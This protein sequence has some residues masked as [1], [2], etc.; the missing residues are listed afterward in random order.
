MANLIFNAGLMK[1]IVLIGVVLLAGCGQQPQEVQ[2]KPNTWNAMKVQ[3]NNLVNQEELS[4]FDKEILKISLN[5]TNKQFCDNANNKSLCK[6]LYEKEIKN[7][8][9]WNCEKLTILKQ[10]C[11]DQKYFNERDC[12]KISDDLLKRK[13]RFQVEYDK[14]IQNHDVNFCNK[15]PRTMK[16]EC[17]QKMK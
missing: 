9:S 8:Q 13:C 7:Y 5:K 4:K 12:D 10:K 15:L 2:I 14:A 1:K 6:Q 3:E 11:L 16:E 17:F